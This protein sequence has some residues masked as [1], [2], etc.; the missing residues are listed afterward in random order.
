[1]LHLL[2]YI[3]YILIIA[4]VGLAIWFVPKYSY[5]KKNPG[6]CVNLTKNL[7][8]CGDQSNLNEVFNSS[9]KDKQTPISDYSSTN[10]D[11]D[12]TQD[13]KKAIEQE[14]NK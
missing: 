8:Y 9:I 10:T 11:Q 2:K 6:Y 7:Y 14:L 5:V 13:F 1:M 4:L 3:F 12:L